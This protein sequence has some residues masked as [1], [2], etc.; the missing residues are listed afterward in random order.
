MRKN[1]STGLRFLTNAS[2]KDKS[3]YIRAARETGFDIFVGDEAVESSTSTSDSISIWTNER[4]RTDHAPFWRRVKELREGRDACTV[5]R[6]IV[7]LC[8][9]LG[10]SVADL[11]KEC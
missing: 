9:A 5:I 7:V 10:V 3:L 1:T 8:K 4:A 2:A 6:A 11:T